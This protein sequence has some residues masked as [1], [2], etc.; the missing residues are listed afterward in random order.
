MWLLH[1]LK[2][3]NDREEISKSMVGRTM[4]VLTVK[5]YIHAVGKRNERILKYRELHQEGN[6]H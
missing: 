4:C 3:K 6:K 1:F 2:Q 5:F